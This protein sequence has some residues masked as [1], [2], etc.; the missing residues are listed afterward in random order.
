MKINNFTVL[1]EQQLACLVN[2]LM[3]PQKA[4]LNFTM[5]VKPTYE[6]KKGSA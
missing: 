6:A 2:Q 1:K 3:K 5:S 4:L